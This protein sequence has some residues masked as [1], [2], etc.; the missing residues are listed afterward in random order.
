MVRWVLLVAACVLF[1]GG[2][3]RYDLGVFLGLR[4]IKS[5]TAHV[6]LSE[7]DTFSREGVFNITRHPWYLGSLMLLWSALPVYHE[8][9]V[10]GAVVLTLYLFVGTMLE[11]R[12]LVAECGERYRAYQQQ[13]SM[14]L[15]WKWLL[16]FF[17][18]RQR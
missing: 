15:P 17:S 16:G 11:E 7:D 13:V 2:A 14:L 1:V 4:Q 6:L 9:T 8:A 10:I 3:R 18:R 5:G 12:K